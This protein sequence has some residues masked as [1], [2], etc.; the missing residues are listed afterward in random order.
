MQ[1]LVASI[2]CLGLVLIALGGCSSSTSPAGPQPTARLRV[3]HA[4]PDLG[5]V[6]VYLEGAT[7]PWAEDLAYRQAST[8]LSGRPQDVVLVFRAAGAPADAVPVFTSDVLAQTA[9]ASSSTIVCGLAG[10][11]DAADRLRLLAYADSWEAHAEDETRV[12]VV[13]AGA[14]V[15]A[16]QVA[17]AGGA[18]LAEDL[19]RFGDSGLGGEPCPAD[20]PLSITVTGAGAAWSFFVAPLA[21][22]QDHYFVVTGLKG[23]VAPHHVALLTVGPGGVQDPLPAGR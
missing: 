5:V 14:D 18:V 11:S 8:Y 9:G 4:S 16:L 10:S 23:A 3:V 15:D 2:F 6:D 19:A 1:R 21:A 13:H 12:R 22:D 7:R 17:I 20:A